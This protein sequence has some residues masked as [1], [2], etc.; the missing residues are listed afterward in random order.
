MAKLFANSGDPDQMPRSAVSDLGLHC[1]L[2]TLLQLFSQLQ[3]VKC[4][5][6]LTEWQTV[7]TLIRLLLFTQEY[8]Q[9]GR[10]MA[11][12]F[13]K[14]I[15]SLSCNLLLVTNPDLT[16][17]LTTSNPQAWFVFINMILHEDFEF[18]IQYE[19]RKLLH[20][21]FQTHSIILKVDT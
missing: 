14:Q 20:A 7:G 13:F 5:N 16:C 4:L 2:I 10:N 11:E 17:N 6:V 19:H 12:L 1:L 21:I 18:N 9:I 3:R 8:V 15:Y